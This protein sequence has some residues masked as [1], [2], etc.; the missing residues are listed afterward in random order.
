MLK[1]VKQLFNFD[2]KTKIPKSTTSERPSHCSSSDINLIR[3]SDKKMVVLADESIV[4]NHFNYM[5]VYG[6]DRMGL[7]VTVFVFSTH[8]TSID[9]H[10]PIRIHTER[11]GSNQEL[12]NILHRF[13]IK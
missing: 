10:L 13:F 11:F 12:N 7:N 9:P 3:E 2:F 5:L 4:S 1:F 8:A 6:K